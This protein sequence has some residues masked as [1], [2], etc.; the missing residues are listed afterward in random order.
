MK[1]KGFTLIELL[2][3]IVILA[4]IAL[5]AVPIVLDVIKDSKDSSNK[6]SIELYGSAVEQAVAREKLNGNTLPSGKY[7]T[8]DGKTLTNGSTT[9]KVDYE[10]SKVVCD[11]YLMSD[12]K[13]SLNSCKVN[14]KATEYIYGEKVYYNGE[15]VYFDVASGKQCSEEEYNDSYGDVIADDG[16]E[17]VTIQGYQNSNLGYNGTNP[18]DKQNSCLKFYAF[19]DDGGDRVNLILDHDTTKETDWGTYSCKKKSDGTYVSA[20]TLGE[21]FTQLKTD[22]SSWIGTEPP[23]NYTM[24]QR[25]QYVVDNVLSDV[26]SDVYYT[27]DYSDYKARLITAGEIATITG[28]TSWDETTAINRFTDWYFFDSKTNT[29]SSTCKNGNT[30]GCKYGWLYD[31]TATSCTMYGCLNDADSIS[32]NYGYWT[33]TSNILAAWIVASDGV[34]YT[35]GIDGYSSYGVRPVIEVLKSKLN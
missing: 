32:S 13:V 12:G 27:I 20:I 4:I 17:G 9:F 33:A 22:T 18:K 11:V 26:Y 35:D 8:T 15:V 23:S 2:A 28:N 3:V 34:L 21:V 14:D 25:G 6:R 1:K 5:I 10:K 16:L 19:N 24:D 7:T 31:R 29:P 30:S